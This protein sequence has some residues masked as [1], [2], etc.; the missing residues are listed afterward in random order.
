MKAGRLSLVLVL[1]LSM[2]FMA[3]CGGGGGK[4]GDV[5]KALEAYA[6]NMDSFISAMNS[7]EDAGAAAKAMNEFAD[8]MEALKPKME[9]LEKEFPELENEENL[10]EELK[11]YVDKMKNIGP[12]MMTAFMKVEQFKDDPEVAKAQ[13]RINAIMQ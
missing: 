9:A 10:P 11:V 8:K 5:K 4:Y 7:A 12:Q 6:A 2:A 1:G 3:A 13:E